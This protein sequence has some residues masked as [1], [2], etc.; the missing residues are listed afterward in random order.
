WPTIT[1][2]TRSGTLNVDDPSPLP[3]GAGSSVVPACPPRIAFHKSAYVV[4][5]T[6]DP[7][8]NSH[9]VGADAATDVFRSPVVCSHSFNAADRLS[10]SSPPLIALTIC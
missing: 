2:P 1:R 4:R 7:S 9:P 5:D 8:H 6:A 3:Y 10:L